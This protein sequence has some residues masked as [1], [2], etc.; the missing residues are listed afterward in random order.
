MPISTK[1][2]ARKTPPGSA[3]KKPVAA[4]A[5]SPRV[6]AVDKAANE[7][8]L[9]DLA[10]SLSRIELS[11]LAG[12]LVKGWRE[13]LEAI[14]SANRASYAGL[15]ALVSRQ[16]KMIQDA[17]GEWRTASMVMRKIGPKDTVRHLD[18]LAMASFQLALA[19]IRELADLAAR[20]QRDAFDI[21][22]RR[23]NHNLDDVQRVL[24]K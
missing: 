23:I 19:D 18:K 2:P 6:A 21:V 24:L 5:R 9:R 14:V 12:W 11:G 20:S 4:E 1:S 16:A 10:A 7:R 3:A 17:A 8:S 22:H 15:Q 13:D